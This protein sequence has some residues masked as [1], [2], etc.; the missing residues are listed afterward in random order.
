MNEELWCWGSNSHGQLGIEDFN[1]DESHVP[2][3]SGIPGSSML[4]DAALD[5]H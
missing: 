5:L 2:V 4:L 1:S 3:K